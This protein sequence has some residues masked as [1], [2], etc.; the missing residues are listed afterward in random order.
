MDDYVICRES[1]CV[2]EREGGGRGR[3]IDSALLFQS[4]YYFFLCLFLLQC[5]APLESM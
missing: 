5:P 3:E 4:S 1:V 2:C